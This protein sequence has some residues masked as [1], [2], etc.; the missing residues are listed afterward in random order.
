MLFLYSKIFYRIGRR[1]AIVLFEAGLI[2][3]GIAASFSTAPEMLICFRFLVGAF[4]AS[5]LLVSC[6]LSKYVEIKLAP[7]CRYHFQIHIFAWKLFYFMTISIKFV[8]RGPISNRLAFVQIGLAPNRRQ[9]LTNDDPVHCHIRVAI[10]SFRTGIR[11]KAW[12]NDYMHL[13]QWNVS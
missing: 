6:V 1:R 4:A 11:I 3:C 5:S 13:K 10:Q 8:V 12:I 9:A 2:A 7:F